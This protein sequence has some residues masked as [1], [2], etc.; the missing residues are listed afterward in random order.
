[1]QEAEKKRKKTIIRR[2]NPASK[3]NYL[4][5]LFENYNYIDRAGRHQKKTR[6]NKKNKKNL[7]KKYQIFSKYFSK[8]TLE[9]KTS[10]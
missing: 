1:L 7:E 9:K 4:K 5:K 2:D 8:A 3:E 6:R 10:I